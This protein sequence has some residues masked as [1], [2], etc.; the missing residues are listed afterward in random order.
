MNNANPKVDIYLKKTKQWREE[1]TQLREIALDCGLTEE[2]KWGKPCYTVDGNNVIILQG[3]KESC[4]MM[5]TKGALLKDPKRILEKP[6][7]NTQSARRIRF[8]GVQEIVA[9]KTAIKQLINDTVKV[10]K[11]GLKVEFKETKDFTVPVEL[12]SQLDKTPALKKAFASLTPGRQRG[13]LLY[14]A[15]A[16]QAKTRESRVEKC[17]PRI[18]DGLGLHD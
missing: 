11:A 3:F 7:E 4:A 5:F 8:T 12:Q 9:L 1:I 2:L 18:L 17:I 6:G 13:Y 14:F 15:G 10:E 16:K